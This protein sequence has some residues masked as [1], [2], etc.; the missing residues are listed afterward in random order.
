MVLTSSSES[1]DDEYLVQIQQRRRRRIF[2]TRINFSFTITDFAFNEKF[3]VCKTTVEY[4]IN[5]I[6]NHYHNATENQQ[7]TTFMIWSSIYVLVDIF[8]YFTLILLHKLLTLHLQI[9]QELTWQ[10]FV[11]T[12]LQ[13]CHGQL[14]WNST[15]VFDNCRVL[16]NAFT[17]VT[18]CQNVTYRFWTYLSPLLNKPTATIR[19]LCQKLTK[20]SDCHLY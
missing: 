15:M 9:C 5:R 12:I 18:I 8:F 10:E 17:I 13:I 20:L 6:S 3:R 16:L 11:A 14:S 7:S 1:S 4:I 19:Q 2:K